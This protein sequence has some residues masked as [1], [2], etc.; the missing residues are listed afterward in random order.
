MKSPIIMNVYGLFL[1]LCG[2]V[3]FALAGF[4]A[5][6]VTAVIVGGATAA[7]MIVCGALARMLSRNRALGMIGIHAG[8]VLPL[9]FA[10][11]FGWRAWQAYADPA[12]LYLA[13]IL[14]IMAIGSVV[15]FVLILR[16]RPAPAMR[17]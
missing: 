10:V 14:A 1:A 7:V 12:K 6:A 15:A 16:T 17:V 8:L 4:A 13:V 5:N 11:L 3:A 9:I 2:F